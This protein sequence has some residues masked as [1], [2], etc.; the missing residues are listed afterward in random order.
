MTTVNWIEPAF[1]P[2]AVNDV[3][4]RLVASGFDALLSTEVREVLN[5]WRSSHSFPL[6]TL[7]VGLRSKATSVYRHSIVA[8]RLKRVPSIVQKLQRFP[9]MKLARMQDIGGARAVVSS[10]EQ[11]DRLR[12]HYY[13]SRARHKLANEKD[14]IRNPKA[15]GY[16][17]IH[18]VY[19]Y[20][21][22]R[23]NV[24]NGLQ[25]ELQLRSRTQHAWAT[26]VETVGTFLGESLKSSQGSEKWLRFFELI[27]SGFAMSEG[28]PLADNVPQDHGQLVH[29]IRKASQR[30]KVEETLTQF[31]TALRVV[32][33]PELHHIK[34]FLLVL[35]PRVRVETIGF[36][37][38]AEATDRYLEEERRV[39]TTSGD[40]VLVASDSLESMQR[41]FPNYFA[42]S[43]RFLQDM[44]RLLSPDRGRQGRLDL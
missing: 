27:G 5:N 43:R 25:I 39:G 12:Q 34:Y 41:A 24:Y 23:N 40:V 32:G 3:G 10:V 1:R 4:E 6:N 28:G 21:S 14:Y 17:G 2:R 31:R 19:R 30:L 35:Q 36:S 18:L 7:Q 22:D 42:D 11:V 26:T 20:H 16:R 33:H 8:Q 15:S 9:Q 38:L 29:E 37:E 13:Q 44:R